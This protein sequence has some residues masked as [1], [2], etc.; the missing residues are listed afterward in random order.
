[1]CVVCVVCLWFVGGMS[2]VLLKF[3]VCVCLWFVCNRSWV[4][5]RCAVLYGMC[6][7]N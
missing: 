1:M 6:D 2:G 4:I 5:C 3:G 7:M